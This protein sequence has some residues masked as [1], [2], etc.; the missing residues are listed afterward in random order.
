MPKLWQNFRSGMFLFAPI[1]IGAMVG[2]TLW[3]LFAQFN[4]NLVH[5]AW[6]NYA[7]NFL[8]LA[9]L[10]FLA[11]WLLGIPFIRNGLKSLFSKI[12]FVSAISD[13]FLEN[14]ST[15]AIKK[16]DFP[17]VLCRC[18]GPRC[19][20]YGL[21]TKEIVVSIGEA[22][23]ILCAVFYPTSP[24][25]F[26]GG[27]FYALKSDLIYTGSKGGL[28]D[29]VKIATSFGMKGDIFQNIKVSSKI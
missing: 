15:D 10:I 6:L 28:S 27:V 9:V 1:V 20:I 8:I 2:K 17:L 22:Q 29:L 7:L 12:P 16:N 14:D 19:W 18:L 3:D 21:V 4:V 11:G 5:S 13:Y 23:E 26:T 25:P 24:V